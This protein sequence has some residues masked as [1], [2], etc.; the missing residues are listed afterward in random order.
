MKNGTLTEARIDESARRLLRGKFELGLFDNP[1]VDA[2]AA[3]TIVGGAAARAE[4]VAAQAAAH[5]VLTNASEG[6]ARLPLGPGLRVYAEGVPPSS[7]ADRAT[8]VETPAEADV[9][10]LRL[11]APFE[12]RGEQGT[13]ESFFRAGSLEF[14]PA[15]VARVQAIAATVPTIVDV[16]LDRP[17]IL[18]PLAE[19]AAALIVNFGASA[20]AFIRV[21]FGAAQPLG[22]LPFDIPSSMAAVEASRPDVPF[23]TAGATFRFGDGLSLS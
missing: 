2:T 4:G 11:Q 10:V 16:Y 14:P 13:I 1:F 19:S 3:E 17:A 22:R 15:E 23:D 18:D 9:A 12:Q 20:E 6:P 8:V 5:T 21:L 7:F